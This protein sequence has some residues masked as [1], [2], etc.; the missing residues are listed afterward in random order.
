L[1]DLHYGDR[2]S[3]VRD[4]AQLNPLREGIA[5]L[6][7]N[8]DTLD[9]R[10]GPRPDFTTRLRTELQSWIES[11][12]VET[13]LLTGNHDP[14]LS[15]EHTLDLAGGRVFVTHGD[16]I[17]DNI[18]P[19]GRDAATIDRLLAAGLAQVGPPAREQLASRLALWRTVSAQIPQRHQSEPHGLKYALH[20][21]ADTVWPPL[22]VLRILR[23]WRQTPALAEALTQRHRPRAKFIIIGHTHR[24]GVWRTR[25]GIVVINTGSFCPPVGGCAVD[26]SPTRLSVRRVERRRGEFHI[27]KSMAEFTLADI[28]TSPTLHP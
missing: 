6:V 25:S 28:P 26:L 18:V 22:R 5:Q 23:A 10:M 19:W 7:L 2:A 11:G 12:G 16:I 20:F 1:S 14:D 3:Q 27:G 8:G 17:F 15:T 24:P 21:M 9:T 4:L 13:T